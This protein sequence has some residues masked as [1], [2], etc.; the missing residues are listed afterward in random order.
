MGGMFWTGN[1]ADTTGPAAPQRDVS[2][3]IKQLTEDIQR[4]KLMNQAMWEL[5]RDRARLTDKDL[6]EKA[7]E[8]DLRDGKQD[9]RMSETALRCPSCNRV[10]SSR[11]WR[12]LYC[13]QDFEKPVMG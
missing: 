11:H 7:L 4:L 3:D 6:E 5:I 9:G 8:I 2:G 1:I 13:G 12:C 10:S